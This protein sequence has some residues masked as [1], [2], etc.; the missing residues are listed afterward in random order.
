MVNDI[1]KTLPQ[2]TDT[3]NQL[4][5]I[6]IS[7]QEV[8]D[9]LDSLN[10]TKACGPDLISPRL[11]KEGASMVSKPLATVFN[12]T[13]FQGYFPSNWKDSNVT[14]IHKKE[15]KS[16]PSKYRPISLLRQLGKLWKG[17]CI[18]ICSIS[19]VKMVFSLPFN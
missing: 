1:N 13:L 3:Y 9:V 11:L 4:H 17:A 15:D 6:N 2:R 19:S 18:K 12:Q 5:S 7:E 16:L 8:R 14:T 10:V